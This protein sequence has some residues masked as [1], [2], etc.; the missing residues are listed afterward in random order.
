[1]EQAGGW[2]FRKGKSHTVCYAPDGINMIT[3]GHTPSVNNFLNA[4]RRQL[5]HFGQ[6]HVAMHL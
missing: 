4:I 1:M 3:L 5:N 6:R 2:R